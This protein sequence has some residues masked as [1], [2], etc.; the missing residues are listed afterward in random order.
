MQKNFMTSA[1]ERTLEQELGTHETGEEP[2]IKTA[3]AGADTAS[4]HK[5]DDART[6]LLEAQP[7][8]DLNINQDD[9]RYSSASNISD[10]NVRSA[11][12]L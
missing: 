5:D 4:Q 9:L 10:Q 11:Q 8:C 7:A 3:G 1:E 12:Q 6:A 2:G